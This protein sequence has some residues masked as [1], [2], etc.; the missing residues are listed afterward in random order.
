MGRLDIGNV[1]LIPTLPEALDRVS[2]P[3]LSLT[4]VLQNT[5]APTRARAKTQNAKKHLK[6][7]ELV[8]TP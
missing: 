6:A 5:H 8:A 3:D 7:A 4:L 1:R 2:L